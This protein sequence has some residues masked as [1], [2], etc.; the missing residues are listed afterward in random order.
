MV[1]N[2]LAKSKKSDANYLNWCLCLEIDSFDAGET[3]FW[4][5]LQ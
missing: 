5:A 3:G 4:M 2:Q 1:T